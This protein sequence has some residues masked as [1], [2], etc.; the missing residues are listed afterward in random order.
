MMFCCNGTTTCNRL[1]D[2]A[3]LP[4]FLQFDD[5]IVRPPYDYTTW[6]QSNET[7]ANMK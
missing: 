2:P 3:C 5:S 1:G 4:E 6:V 7:G